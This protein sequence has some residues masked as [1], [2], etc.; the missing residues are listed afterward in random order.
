MFFLLFFFCFS[1][2][3]LSVYLSGFF[4]FADFLSTF[5]VLRFCLSLFSFLFPVSKIFLELS[6][7]LSLVDTT[8][9]FVSFSWRHRSS[10][11]FFRV[12]EEVAFAFHR[13]YF[14]IPSHP[15]FADVSIA[16]YLL[17]LAISAG[18][19]QRKPKCGNSD[20]EE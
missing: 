16:S 1:S 17:W 12:S 18:G 14:P 4:P 15:S 19:R 13:Y 6:L 2:V 8:C 10:V 7:S 5:S 9:D 3:S 20:K 11:F